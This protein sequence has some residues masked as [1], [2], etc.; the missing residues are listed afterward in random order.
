M[1]GQNAAQEIEN[2]SLSDNTIIDDMAHSS[3][4]ILWQIDKISVF[5]FRLMSQQII[6]INIT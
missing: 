6:P 2:V 5:L 1:F 4:E 3:E